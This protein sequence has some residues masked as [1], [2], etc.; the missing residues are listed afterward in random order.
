M[1][2]NLFKI[3][4]TLWQDLI[5]VWPRFWISFL[6]SSSWLV[7]SCLYWH[8]GLNMRRRW[9]FTPWR[10]SLDGHLDCRRFF[11]YTNYEIKMQIW[12]FVP[13]KITIL[14]FYNHH[15]VSIKIPEVGPL[16]CMC[17]NTF[18]LCSWSLLI[19]LTAKLLEVRGGGGRGF[20]VIIA[21]GD[22]GRFLNRKLCS[23]LS[24]WKNFCTFTLNY[25]L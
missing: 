19:A 13:Y 10:G 2:C 22:G 1:Q 15:S 18:C 5:H 25:E 6:I 9:M 3:T 23:L 16:W 20:S 24:N 21:F 14:S 11:C 4:V 17:L 12:S 7:T 8:F